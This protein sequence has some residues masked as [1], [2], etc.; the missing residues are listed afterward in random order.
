[1]TS[2][3]GGRLKHSPTS[4]GDV[5]DVEARIRR[6][7][8]FME[9]YGNRSVP[10]EERLTRSELREHEEIVRA[11]LSVYSRANQFVEDFRKRTGAG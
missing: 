10:L 6:I 9:R 4:R 8:G 1:M 3:C 7:E 5:P 2:G 11:L